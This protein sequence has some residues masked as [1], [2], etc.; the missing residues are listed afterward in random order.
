MNWDRFTSSRDQHLDA[1]DDPPER[2]PDELTDSERE[3]M[4][5]AGVE[6]KEL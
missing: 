2:E 3:E 5:E 6:G 4:F 1:T